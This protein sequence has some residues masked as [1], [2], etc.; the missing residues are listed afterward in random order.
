MSYA[1]FDR[2]LSNISFSFNVGIGT[3]RALSRLHVIGDNCTVGNVGIGTT[4][5][6]QALHVVGNT[7]LSSNL[8]IGT[9]TPTSPC[10]IV[11]NTTSAACRIIQQNGLGDAL[12][13]TASFP[14]NTPAFVI[15]SIGQIGICTSTPVQTLHVEGSECV[16][17]A[18]GI[19]TQNPVSTLHVVG[20]GAVMGNL[21]IGTLFPTQTFHVEGV[22]YVNGSIG[23][24]TSSPTTALDV[25]GTI[26]ATSY[27]GLPSASTATAGIVMLDDTFPVTSTSSNVAPTVNA[28]KRVYDL[29]NRGTGGSSQWSS[30]SSGIVISS[31]VGIG[32]ANPLT[33]LHVVGTQFVSGSIGIGTST[34]STA[35]D[36]FGTIK[37]TTYQGLPAASTSVTGIV[38]LDDTY[39]V[40]SASANLAPTVNA[41]KQ[42]YDMANTKVSSQWATVVGGIHTSGNV[43]IA[44]ATPTTTLDVF[45]TIKA[46]TYQGLPAASTSV[47]GI[48]R[49]DDTYPVT[50]TSVNLAPTVNAVKKV[51]DLANGKVSSQWTSVVNGIQIQSANVGIGTTNPQAALHVVGTTRGVP[52]I[53][54]TGTFNATSFTVNL[55]PTTYKVHVIYFRGVG[56][57]LSGGVHAC[58]LRVGTAGTIL[59]SGYSKS[60]QTD[61]GTGD[62][63]IIGPIAAGT[64]I[65]GTITTYNLDSGTSPQVLVDVSFSTPG[66]PVRVSGA[67]TLTSNNAASINIFGLYFTDFDGSN[68]ISTASGEYYVV[69]YPL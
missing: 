31:N 66:N 12:T 11:A 20:N 37:A 58:R 33:T 54:A 44:T 15:N 65:A 4:R 52:A 26:T 27:N 32:T 5:P 6:M 53:Y 43:G 34:P 63:P 2:S 45:G 69:G 25:V 39:P 35:L 68:R 30:V 40:I 46:T 62:G 36:V 67:F 13:V 9:T 64:Q 61:T 47:A 23:I 8:G 14:A 51:Y 29:A 3:T 38:R 10:H 22:Q 7:H 18:L 19:G 48:V 41:L 57:N 28:L 55:Q 17:G 60:L 16:S 24:G 59:T 21:G 49:L 1:I 56:T 50:S 42:V